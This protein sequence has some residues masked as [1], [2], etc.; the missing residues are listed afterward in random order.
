MPKKKTQNIP[1]MQR[2]TNG[3]A[4]DNRVNENERKMAL[5]QLQ[6]MFTNQLEPGIVSL[7]LSECEFNGK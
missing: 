6:E 4:R 7:V 2:T 3:K 1:E 5:A